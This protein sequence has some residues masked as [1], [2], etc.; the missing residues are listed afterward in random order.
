MSDRRMS[1][2]RK[3]LREPDS[4]FAI[5]PWPRQGAW[6]EATVDYLTLTLM[7][8][9]AVVIP[10]CRNL[11]APQ[12]E[13]RPPRDGDRENPLDGP[14]MRNPLTPMSHCRLRSPL[15]LGS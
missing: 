3:H 1:D 7:V 5:D 13:E 9:A 8:G 11:T 12:K 4:I 15:A 2:H 14:G 10:T 6:L